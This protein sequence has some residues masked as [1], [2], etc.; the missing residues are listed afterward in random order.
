MQL[1]KLFSILVLIY[2]SINGIIKLAHG[3]IKTG[4][5][6]LC[7]APILLIVYEIVKA[8]NKKRDA[9]IE[10]ELAYSEENLPKSKLFKDE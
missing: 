4:I 6:I 10:E 5:I 1:F 9:K 3:D 2:A 7:C 8:I